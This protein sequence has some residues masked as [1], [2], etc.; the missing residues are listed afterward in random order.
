MAAVTGKNVQKQPVERPE[1]PHSQTIPLTTY[2][3]SNMH[4]NYFLTIS[5][6]TRP[7]NCGKSEGL[8]L[9]SFT[10]VAKIADKV[11]FWITIVKVTA[12][13]LT[14]ITHFCQIKTILSFYFSYLIILKL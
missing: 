14:I 10:L 11:Y 13:L 3:T 2:Q 9:N 8:F 1:V 6:C 4:I 7:R 12:I 5:S